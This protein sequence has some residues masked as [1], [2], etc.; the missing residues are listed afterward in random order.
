M[1]SKTR[2]EYATRYH[3]NGTVTVW[4]VYQQ[5]WLRQVGIVPSAVLATLT[6]EDRERVLHHTLPDRRIEALRREAAI[7][8]DA[9]QVAICDRALAGNG[10]AR[11]ECA[12]VI[13]AAA[14]QE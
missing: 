5:Q 10:D 12:R 7:A 4:D 8:G 3:R 9:D 13:A 6:H 14:A 1:A 11:L 2:S